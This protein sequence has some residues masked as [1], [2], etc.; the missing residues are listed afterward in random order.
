MSGGS[1]EKTVEIENVEEGMKL[2]RDIEN[3]FGGVILPAGTILTDSKIARLKRLDYQKAKVFKESPEEL[4]ENMKEFS[5]KEKFYREEIKRTALLYKKIKFREA[6]DEDI[7]DSLY[8][9]AMD[10][11]T[12]LEISDLLNMVKGVD[13][14]TYTHLLNV[15]ILSNMMGNWLDFNQAK[16]ERL[17]KAGL[18]H[19]VGKS[20]IPEEILQKPAS[21]SPEEYELMKEHSYYGYNIVDKAQFI[22][23]ETALGVL[24][25][26]EYYNGSGY[27]LNLAGDNIPLFGR[28]IAIVD[29]FD[30]ITSERIYQQKSSPFTAIEKIQRENFGYCDPRLKKLFLEKIPNFFIREKVK[31]NNG[32]IGE[33]VFVSARSPSTPVVKVEGDYLDLSNSTEIEIEEILK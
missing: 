26:H 9:N 2:A 23:K 24:T 17:T 11:S 7:L 27:P 32:K 31:L 6:I 14:Y 5:R 10:L 29:A 4:D 12:K 13:E 16:L 20:K 22:S 18:L 21:L 19:D 1:E 33:V 25:H 28:I 15:G 30:A 3:R 8:E